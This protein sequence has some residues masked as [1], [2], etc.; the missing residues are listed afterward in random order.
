MRQALRMATSPG[1]TAPISRTLA[2]GLGA[3]AD[4]DATPLAGALRSPAE[5]LADAIRQRFKAQSTAGDNLGFVAAEG[6]R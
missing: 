3:L 4:A 5:L 1:F 2:G 6:T